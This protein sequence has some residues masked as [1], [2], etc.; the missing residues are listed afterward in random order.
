LKFHALSALFKDPTEWSTMI[1]GVFE[2]LHNGAK[3]ENN[4]LRIAG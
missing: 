4:W 2:K 1:D 3:L